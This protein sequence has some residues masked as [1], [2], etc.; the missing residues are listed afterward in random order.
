MDRIRKNRIVTFIRT[1]LVF[2]SRLKDLKDYDRVKIYRY[3]LRN[4]GCYDPRLLQELVQEG[5]ITFDDQWFFTIKEKQGKIDISLLV[6]ASRK[7]KTTKPLTPL[8]LWM[9]NQLHYVELKDVNKKDIPVYF[10]TFMKY[11]DKHIEHFFKV[12]NFS[13]RIHTPVVN[14][15]G[16][17]RFKIRFHGKR[18]A[19]LDVHQMQPTI[20]ARV[21]YDNVGSNTFS[22]AIFN[23]KDIYNRLKE[24]ASLEDRPAAKKYFFQLIFGQPMN[25]IRRLFKGDP[26]WVD[27]INK[28]KSTT[29]PK[30]PHHHLQHTNLAWLLQYSE[31]QVMTD[32]WNDLKKKDIP[33]LSI[34]DEI[35]C[36]ITDTDKVKKVM[37]NQLKKHFRTFT[38]NVKT[39]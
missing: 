4:I 6:N 16:D 27:W 24:E 13:E 7:D 36:K 20:L 32:I 23:G 12:D 29:E 38:I 15:K 25:D 37:E 31:V 33:F 26:K 35:L 14:L 39:E 11:R 3:E 2:K 9:R 5:R 34:H 30:N 17:L 18:I 8:H 28:Y 1:K 10:S 21:L 22:D 19:S